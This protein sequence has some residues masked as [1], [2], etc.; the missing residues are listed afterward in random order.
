MGGPASNL[1]TYG[2]TTPS[3]AVEP[4]EVKDATEEV[5]TEEE[6]TEDAK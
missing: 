6:S 4:A 1:N 3:D 5:V 2:T